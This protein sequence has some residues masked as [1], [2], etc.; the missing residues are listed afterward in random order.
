MFDKRD[1]SVDSLIVIMA[2]SAICYWIVCGYQVV[3]GREVSS[4]LTLGGGFATMMGVFAAG[5]TARDRLSSPG[6][7][8]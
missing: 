2:I 7:T 4:P 6:G 8:Q 5:K 3:L 1:M